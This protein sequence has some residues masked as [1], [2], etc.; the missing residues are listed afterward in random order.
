M[1]ASR[2][3]S[4]SIEF[5][6]FEITAEEREQDDPDFPNTS[7]PITNAKLI[8]PWKEKFLNNG[9]ITNIWEIAKNIQPPRS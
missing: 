4:T 8:L 1:E 7:L 6:D 3:D 5:A 9:R 2:S